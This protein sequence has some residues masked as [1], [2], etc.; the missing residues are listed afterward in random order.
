MK[1]KIMSLLGS[2]Q[3]SW[4]DFVEQSERILDGLTYLGSYFVSL[5]S[6]NLFKTNDTAKII[7]K[8][9]LQI[10]I[11]YNVKYILSTGY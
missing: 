8:S 11:S 10:N 1:L 7:T 4:K 9:L 2:F 5:G 6:S 3:S